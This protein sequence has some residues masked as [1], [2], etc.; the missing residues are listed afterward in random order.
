MQA[1]ISLVGK[2]DPS[3]AK[4]LKETQKQLNAAVK[5]MDVSS[6]F[7][8]G[9]G[10]MGAVAAKG[11]AVVGGAAASAATAVGGAALQNYASYE[12]MVGGVETLFGAGGKSLEE[13]AA[14]V[15]Q[16]VDEASG[17]YDQLMAA[18]QAVMDNAASAWNQA[19][20]SGNSYME[21]ATMMSASLIQS[22]GGDTQAAA[23]MV[24]VAIKDMSDNANKFGTD[25]GSIQMT[26]QSLMRGNYAMLDNLRLGYGGTKTELERL[27]KDASELTGEALDPSKFS[28]VIKAIH[29]VQE[30]MGIT[31][32]TMS[33]AATTI[34]GSIGSA[35]AAWDNWLTGLGRSDADM[36]ALTGQLLDAVGAVADNIGPAVQRIGS[37]MADY[38]PRALQGAVSRVGPLVAETLSGV[39]NSA[40]GMLGIELPGFD[41]SAIMG[42]FSTVGPAI[43]QVMAALGPPIQN[44]VNAVL[45]PLMS[46][47]QS[48]MPFLASL[49]SAILPPII[50]FV[51]PIASML[52]NIAAA[53][54]PMLTAA[55]NALNPVI[56]VIISVILTLT[57]I[58]SGAFSAFQLLS[59]PISTLGSALMPAVSA[60]AQAIS[61][62]FQA[63]GPS[64]SAVIGFMSSLWAAIQPVVSILGSLVSLAMQ[65]ASALASIG[66][67]II[68]GIGSL[69]G[70][71]TGGF[72]TGPYV[73]GEDP[74]YPNEAV[75]SFNPAYRAQNLRYWERAGH[76]LGA[77]PSVAAATSAGGGGS[78]YDFS[79]MTFAP[80]VEVKGNASK[81]DIIA[82]I[83]ACEAEFVD[84]VKSMLAQ[85]SE[86]AYATA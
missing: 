18:Q 69:L 27:V 55:I 23:Q 54:L 67:G 64:I 10:K 78:T 34:E 86:G 3:L 57:P 46:G 26:Y 30:N 51:T 74:S 5:G 45:P 48:L 47:L 72:T 31:G 2:I 1:V 60:A 62:A 13:Y 59:G 71:R 81:D 14:S 39:I 77:T 12:Q 44:F 83:R 63:M 24:D 8:G 6:K 17:K 16:S 50:N 58:I 21:Q 15:G 65:A 53:V 40:A 35:K 4:A 79:G 49:A 20:V 38:L 70:F 73:A 33:E 68:G 52:M 43:Q 41:A 29:A 19:G 56:Q 28:D 82:A 42:V 80:R 75:I 85:D 9:L 22:L 32:T 37:S 61:S 84:T 11:L 66:G 7:W 25:L 76:L 36:G